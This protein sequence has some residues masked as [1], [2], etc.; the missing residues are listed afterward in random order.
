MQ[1]IKKIKD[2]GKQTTAYTKVERINVGDLDGHMVS[3]LVSEGVNTGG[4]ALMDGAQVY[5][6]TSSDLTF[7]SL[8]RLTTLKTDSLI[9]CTF[10]NYPYLRRI[11][12]PALGNQLRGLIL[13]CYVTN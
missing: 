13:L 10:I 6:T 4:G 11:I 5:S 1:E 2:S 9:V 7:Y 3:L 12:M 8:T